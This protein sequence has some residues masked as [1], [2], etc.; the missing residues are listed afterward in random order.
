MRQG[1]AREMLDRFILEYPGSICA[2]DIRFRSARC[3]TRRAITRPPMRST[4]RSIPMSSTFR[5]S[6]NIISGRDMPP[7][8]AGDT[9]KAYGYF[10]NCN[11]DPQYKPHATYYIAYIDYSRGDLQAAK[12]EFASIADNPAYE[13]IIPFYLLQIEF[14]ENNYDYVVAN[15]IPLLAK[16]DRSP[17]TRDFADRQRN[18]ISTWATIR[19][20]WPIWT[21]TPNWAVRWGARN[22]TWPVTAITSTATIRKRSTGSRRSLRAATNWP[23]NASLPPRRR[24]P[25]DGGTR[26]KR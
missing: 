11:T 13:P 5:V 18:L 3:C 4:N 20:R 9:D 1:N 12:R 26:K 6:T 8:C 14:R 17:S 23:Q 21:I 15:G 10:K 19:R 24:L 16:G 7:T 25:A 2:N 22:F